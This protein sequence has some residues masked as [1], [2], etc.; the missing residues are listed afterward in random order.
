MENQQLPQSNNISI[1]SMVIGCILM[2]VGI[3]VGMT[4]VN[5]VMGILV[6]LAQNLGR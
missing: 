4:A 1:S 5:I 2:G 6:A 3:G